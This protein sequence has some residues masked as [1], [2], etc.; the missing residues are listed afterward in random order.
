VALALLV[1]ARVVN[2]TLGVRMCCAGIMHVYTLVARLRSC[3]FIEFCMY[4][5]GWLQKS[6][7]GHLYECI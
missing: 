3:L 7:V 1:L 2:E 4:A 5:R 6:L